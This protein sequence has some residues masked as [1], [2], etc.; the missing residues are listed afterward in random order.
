MGKRLITYSCSFWLLA[1]KSKSVMNESAFEK[2]KRIMDFQ[3]GKCPAKQKIKPIGYIGNIY[4]S[5]GLENNLD[6]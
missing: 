6:V 3:G 2:L 1:F 4:H 5:F